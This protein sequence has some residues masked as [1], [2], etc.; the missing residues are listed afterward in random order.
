MY[1]VQMI[2]TS[3]HYLKAGSQRQ[4][5]VLGRQAECMTWSN[6]W[7]SWQSRPLC[8]LFQQLLIHETAGMNHKIIR[9]SSRSQSNKEEQE[10]KM[11]EGN[12]EIFEGD[13]YVHFLTI[14]WGRDVCVCI[15]INIHLGCTKLYTSDMYSLLNVE[16]SSLEIFFRY[17]KANFSLNNC[18]K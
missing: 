6:S 17:G 14:P 3:H 13:G 5:L 15:Y 9:L 2:S 8:D 18:P 11:T 7:V 4:L 1:T 16:Y 10:G 12:E